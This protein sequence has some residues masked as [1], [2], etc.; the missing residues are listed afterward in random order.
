MKDSNSLEGGWF[1]PQNNYTSSSIS[2]LAGLVTLTYERLVADYLLKS[3]QAFEDKG[4]AAYAISVQV[5]F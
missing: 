3:V 4:F 5:R 2:F 1:L